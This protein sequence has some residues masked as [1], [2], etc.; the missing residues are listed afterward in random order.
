MSQA[1]EHEGLT[2]VSKSDSSDELPRLLQTSS[3]FEL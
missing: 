3:R 1:C 2:I